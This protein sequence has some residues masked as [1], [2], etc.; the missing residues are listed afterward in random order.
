MTE[1]ISIATTLVGAGVL[2]A[3]ISGII[4][5]RLQNAF[6]KDED[7]RI[8]IKEKQDDLKRALFIKKAFLSETKYNILLVSKA[9]QER[10]TL[11]QQLFDLQSYSIFKED[12]A[13]L[14]NAL[15]DKIN[16]L[17]L[18]LFQANSRIGKMHYQ[19]TNFESIRP[20][21]LNQRALLFDFV[22]FLESDLASTA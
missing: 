11:E 10:H 5:Y 9:E 3:L 14:D 7:K 2:S 20:Q 18:E 21:Y 1:W 13:L 6:F 17:Y 4:S 16:K 22:T 12:I 15:A 19:Q 8:K